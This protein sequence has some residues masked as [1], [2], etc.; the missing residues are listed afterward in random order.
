MRIIITVL[1][2][3]FIIYSGYSVYK[4]SSHEASPLSSAMLNQIPASNPIITKTP[5]PV[6]IAKTLRNITLQDINHHQFALSKW[7]GK[8]I[9]VVNFW[10]TWC[11]PCRHELPDFVE[12][13]KQLG[14]K[15]QFVGIA[16]DSESNVETYLKTQSVNY[17]ILLSGID[18]VSLAEQVGDNQDALP[19]TL[20]LNRHGAVI[21]EHTG[22]WAT[23]ALRT[24]LVKLREN[25]V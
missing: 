20:I 22:I 4:K 16:A 8:K 14:S 9:L 19:Y 15:V 5:D 12:L 6:A 3:A 21:N 13:Q 11:P 7:Q 24:E 17:P 2:L 18:G 1:C 23:K 25:A 10:A